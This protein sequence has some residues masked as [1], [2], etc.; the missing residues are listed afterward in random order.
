MEINQTPRRRL[1]QGTSGREEPPG[2]KADE[3]R[4]EFTPSRAACRAAL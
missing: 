2:G 3:T 1:C 4:R